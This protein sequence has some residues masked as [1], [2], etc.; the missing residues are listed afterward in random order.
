MESDTANPAALA[1]D[2][3]VDALALEASIRPASVFAD[4]QI[5]GTLSNDAPAILPE[6]TAAPAMATA[7]AGIDQRWMVI[8]AIAVLAVAAIAVLRSTK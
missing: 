8:L 3:S 1:W 7:D 4:V 2:L 5:Q 6:T